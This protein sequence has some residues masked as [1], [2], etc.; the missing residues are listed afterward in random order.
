MLFQFNIY[1]SLLLIGFVQ[2]IVYGFL[3]LLRGRREGSR[4][5]F[6]MAGILLLLALFVSQ[7]MLG[8]AGWY[9]SRD[10]H[11]TFMF[12]VPFSPP[13]LLGP[14]F[15]CYFLALTNAQFDL[16]RYWR[17]FVPAGLFLLMDAAVAAYD[18]IWWQNIQ[19][20]A[21]TFFYE[22]RGPWYEY[23]ETLD[24]WWWQ[25]LWPLAR[26][27]LLAYL[28]YTFI[29][30]RRYKHYLVANFSNPE[31]LRFHW[32]NRIIVL[33][34]ITFAAGMIGRIL[35]MFLDFSYIQSW[36]YYFIVS[37]AIFV[38]S[39]QAYAQPTRPILRL[40]FA[41][42]I[43]PVEE[44]EVLDAPGDSTSPQR[45]DPE[46][47]QLQQRL[48]KIMVN[49]HPYL[50]PDLNIR[51]LA[52]RLKTNTAYL[53]RVINSGYQLNFSDFINGYRVR[54][55]EQRLRDGDHQQFTFLSLALDCGFNSKATFNRAFRKQTGKSPGDYV[56][57]I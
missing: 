23:F 2:G 31:P 12:Y 33:L 28:I 35:G 42:D 19:G 50:D 29:L 15:F 26:L 11:T 18:L 6:W 46:L 32:L 43:D 9:D 37:V 5:D 22:T 53:S 48:E 4:A 39:I 44:G 14:M 40:S 55:I 24:A 20:K 17:H 10:W 8:F 51:Q 38:L 21:L 13:F 49:E 54:A 25:V 34:T 30:F 1:S 7:W 27:H 3:L 47:Q 57:G 52:E 41:P 16:K 36:Y 56:S 45:L